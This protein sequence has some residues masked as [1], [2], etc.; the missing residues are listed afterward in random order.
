MSSK[1]YF[2]QLLTRHGP[3]VQQTICCT[4]LIV[5]RPISDVNAM[6][7]PK[8]LPR[9][10]SIFLSPLA[11]LKSSEDHKTKLSRSF[12][13]Y[14]F[15]VTATCI[16]F[17]HLKAKVLSTLCNSSK[18]PTPHPN[19]DISVLFELRLLPLPKVE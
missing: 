1:L 9:L 7:R 13:K 19:K 6:Y 5:I 15:P 12:V 8:S 10:C 17:S 14:T 16:L 11:Y 3:V 18:Y 2:L 4:S